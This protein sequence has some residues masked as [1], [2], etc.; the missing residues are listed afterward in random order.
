MTQAMGYAEVSPGELA[1]FVPAHAVTVSRWRK[2]YVPDDAR[3]ERI[4]G[5]LGVRFKWLKAGEEPPTGKRLSDYPY[6]YEG[7]STRSRLAEAPFGIQ[8]PTED[9]LESWTWI[10]VRMAAVANVAEMQALDRER[11]YWW[12]ERVFRAGFKEGEA[13]G[14]AEGGADGTAATG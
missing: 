7:P 1:A 12:F 2:G 13:K 6:P 14:R 5:H 8:L 9:E 10:Q 4:A 11:I 3:I